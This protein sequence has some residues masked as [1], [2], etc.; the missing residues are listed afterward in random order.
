MLGY[1]RF[2]RPYDVCMMHKSFEEVDCSPQQIIGISVRQPLSL[3]ANF[4]MEVG[5]LIDL[6][7]SK[8]TP[9]IVKTV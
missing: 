1:P 3:K 6:R 2:M 4:K 7:G 9:R 5:C 8:P